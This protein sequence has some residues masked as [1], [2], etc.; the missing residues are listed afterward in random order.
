MGLHLKNGWQDSGTILQQKRL[1]KDA[2]CVVAYPSGVVGQGHNFLL[3]T[4]DQMLQVYADFNLQ[5][6]AKVRI[7]SFGR[8]DGLLWDRFDLF[9][10]VSVSSAAA[11]GTGAIGSV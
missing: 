2:S 5:W 7:E 6:A 1:E 8:I 3:A 11:L 4:R 10:Y 9:F